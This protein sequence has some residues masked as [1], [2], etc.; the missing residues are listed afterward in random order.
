MPFR[1]VFPSKSFTSYA[2][3]LY[4]HDLLPP[5]RERIYR[6]YKPSIC[7]FTNDE[8]AMLMNILPDNDIKKILIEHLRRFKEAVM[9]FYFNS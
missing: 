6:G 4:T 1:L 8:F 3:D 5:C 9:I 7:Y 2:Q